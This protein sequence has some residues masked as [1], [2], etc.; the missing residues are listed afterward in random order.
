MPS[1]LLW[2][3]IPADDW[4]RLIKKSIQFQ[5]EHLISVQKHLLESRLW[6]YANLHHKM[7]EQRFNLEKINKAREVEINR[8]IKLRK[9]IPQVKQLLK[10]KKF[11]LSKTSKCFLL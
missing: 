2:N 5:N 7:Q 9:Y 11:E 8:Q 10:Y 1:K 3:F 4:K 6:K